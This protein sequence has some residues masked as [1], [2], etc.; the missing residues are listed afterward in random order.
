MRA[1]ESSIDPY[2]EAKIQEALQ[3]EMEKRTVIVVT[4]RVSTVR[5]SDR[6]I[7][8]QEGEVMDDGTHNQL[9]ER[10]ELYRRL[11]EMQLVSV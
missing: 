10:S 3:R 2:T 8:L 4:H 5:D 11:C 9:L 6:I 1:R 7:I